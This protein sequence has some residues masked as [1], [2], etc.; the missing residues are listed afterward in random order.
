MKVNSF[1]KTMLHNFRRF[2]EQSELLHKQL[3]KTIVKCNK[4]AYARK[5]KLYLFS[6]HFHI[7]RMAQSSL[8]THRHIYYFY[9]FKEKSA[10]SW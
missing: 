1:N 4:A 10:L 9:I 7:K 6:L 2:F 8:R 3:I 5:I